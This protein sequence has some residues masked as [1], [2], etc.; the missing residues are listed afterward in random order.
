M[1]TPPA[2]F[3][4][5]EC[6][7]FDR[8]RCRSR[9]SPR[10]YSRRRS[11]NKVPRNFPG[12]LLLGMGRPR[13]TAALSLI[14][15]SEQTS[16]ALAAHPPDEIAQLTLD[17]G[18]PRPSSRFPAPVNPESGSMPSQDSGR[19]NYSTQI[20]QARPYSGHPNHQGTV[21]CTK[22]ETLRS[23]PQGDVELATQKEIL[24]FKPAL[25]FEQIG[26]KRRKQVDDRKHRVG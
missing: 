25:R 11:N 1:A 10:D 13:G 6:G 19:L 5:A 17:S 21:T 3:V 22:P 20:E 16:G 12:L 15:P 14:C 24:D 2:G 18:P 8:R 4:K 26:Y 23:P 9:A 7:Q